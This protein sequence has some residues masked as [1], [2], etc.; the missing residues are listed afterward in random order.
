[1]KLFLQRFAQTPEYTV[2]RLYID[3]KFY[4]HTM[5]DVVRDLNKEEKIIG[6]TAIPEGTYK[7]IVNRSP[8]FKRD[9]PRL[10]DVPY[11]E[12][13]L[14]HRGNTAKDSGGCILVGENKVKGKVI[15]ST[16]YEIELTNILK[17]A[18]NSGEPIEIEIHNI[19]FMTKD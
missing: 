18:Q 7:V 6:K 19:D 10:L 9:L 1:M 12:G 15:N 11:F 2:G 17:N 16:K 13:I 14:I 8:R 4:C 3:N 5:E